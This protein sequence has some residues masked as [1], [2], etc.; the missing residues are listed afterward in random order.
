MVQIGKAQWVVAR[1]VVEWDVT[2]NTLQIIF[3]HGGV[4]TSSTYTY[5]T[6]EEA[7]QMA[8]RLKDEI[9]AMLG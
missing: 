7:L 8:N 3:A 2:D 6:E 5:D 9:E 1:A 4:E